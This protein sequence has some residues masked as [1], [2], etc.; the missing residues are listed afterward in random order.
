[1]FKVDFEKAHDYVPWS[2]LDYKFQRFMFENRWRV[3]IQACVFSGSHSALVSWCPTEEISI[4]KVLKQGHPLA[5]LSFSSC[6]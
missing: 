1:M 2:F 4:Q 5:H 3:W 6:C